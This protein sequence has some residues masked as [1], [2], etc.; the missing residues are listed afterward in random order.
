MRKFIFILLVSILAFFVL[1]VV[2]YRNDTKIAKTIGI[3]TGK[4]TKTEV[5]ESFGKPSRIQSIKK[6][7]KWYYDNFKINISGMDKIMTLV[8]RFSND[9]LVTNSYF[10]T[11]AATPGIEPINSVPRKIPKSHETDN[12]DK[13]NKA[14]KKEAFQKETSIIDSLVA[15]NEGMKYKRRKMYKES[16]PHFKKSVELDPDFGMGYIELAYAYQS[17][18]E[19]DLAI[20]NYEKGI[21][22]KTDFIPA[23]VMLAQLYVEKGDG[24]KAYYYAKDAQKL[25]PNNKDV[26]EMVAVFEKK[27]GTAIAMEEQA[28]ENGNHVN[29][30]QSDNLIFI[31]PQY[32]E[33]GKIP[34][35]SIESKLLNEYDALVRDIGA[36]NLSEDEAKVILQSK[37]KELIKKY[38]MTE[39][40]FTYMLLKIKYREIPPNGY[41][42]PSEKES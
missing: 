38:N 32:Y 29:V 3:Y 39:E 40:N 25:D 15:F 7:E 41:V 8:I 28:K 12:T 14:K 5:I 2:V 37:V 30:A 36:K 17:T 23:Y 31:G 9:N 13:Q 16:I 6:T 19:N 35:T 18:N 22:L 24:R 27:F 42:P 20:N 4:T 26:N 1:M 21:L 34:I 33:E 11:K 10:L